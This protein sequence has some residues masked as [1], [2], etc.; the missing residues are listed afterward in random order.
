MIINRRSYVSC[1]SS[2]SRVRRYAS[3]SR[4]HGCDSVSG[5]NHFGGR[6]GGSVRIIIHSPLFLPRL[7]AFCTIFRTLFLP[8]TANQGILYDFSYTFDYFCHKSH[9]FVRNIVHFCLIP[10]LMRYFCMKNTHSDHR[11]QPSS[12]IRI[13]LHNRVAS[14]ATTRSYPFTLER[15]GRCSTACST[16]L[17]PTQQLRNKACLRVQLAMRSSH[18]CH[19]CL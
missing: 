14:A 11:C 13:P 17:P 1:I 19:G 9:Y 18:F 8:L 3:Y 2:R 5:C 4:L 6:S 16:V 12:I 10:P 7:T 15:L